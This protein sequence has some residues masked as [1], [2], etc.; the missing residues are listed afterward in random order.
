MSLPL[1]GLMR[2]S[3]S[4]R[5]TL[6]LSITCLTSDLPSAFRLPANSLSRSAHLFYSVYQ[7]SIPK[8]SCQ[9]ALLPNLQSLFLSPDTEI[10][11]LA[12][13]SP[14]DLVRSK[15]DAQCNN[16]SAKPLSLI[17]RGQPPTLLREGDG[18]GHEWPSQGKV[19]S[20]PGYRSL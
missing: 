15:P 2:S 6:R 20:S 18:T 9:L 3:S 5:A 1:L 16:R 17:S 10:D 8:L 4:R 12:C 7:Y 11:V 19:A 14:L 13:D